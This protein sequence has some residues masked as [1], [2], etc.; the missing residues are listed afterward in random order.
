MMR[1]ARTGLA[2]DSKARTI[3]GWFGSGLVL[4]RNGKTIIRENVCHKIHPLF[5]WYLCKFRGYHKIDCSFN[6][7]R[8]VGCEKPHAL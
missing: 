5:I 6:V 3:S 4:R 1:V 7:L 2:T 8:F